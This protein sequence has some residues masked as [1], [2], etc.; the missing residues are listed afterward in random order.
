M[1]GNAFAHGLFYAQRLSD[2]EIARR[3]VSESQFSF[4]SLFSWPSFLIPVLSEGTG[5]AA[6]SWHRELSEQDAAAHDPRSCL[7]MNGAESRCRGPVS[8]G[9]WKGR[10]KP[11][12][13]NLLLG[14]MD[15]IT[16]APASGPFYQLSACRFHPLPATLCVPIKQE[17]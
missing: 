5:A 1:S 8:K 16:Q 15:N 14:L 3:R 2:W 6:F 4:S 7:P 10:S 13:G 9:A 11:C 17:F 12:Q